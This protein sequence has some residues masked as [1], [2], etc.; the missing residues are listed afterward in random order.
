MKKML[1]IFLALA[2]CGMLAACGGSPASVGGENGESGAADQTAPLGAEETGAPMATDPAGE[3]DAAMGAAYGAALEALLEQHVFPDG[4]DAG[5]DGITP[6]EDSK[7]AV[8]DVDGDGKEELLILYTSASMAG[9]KGLVL[10]YNSAAGKLDT[11][12]SAYPLLTFYD[13]GVI[14]EE[15]SHNQGLGGSFWPYNLYQYN[16]DKDCYEMVGMV[17][18]WEKSF[19]PT[20][21]QNNPFPDDVDASGTG[22]VYYIMTD[23]QYDNTHPVDAA[24]YNQ[25]LNGYL[26]GAAPC[27]IEYLPLTQEN[28]AGIEK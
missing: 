15:W 18:A 1:S 26:G 5:F 23:G 16:P 9:M 3:E 10:S 20:D 19:A 24:E 12:L 14:R 2:L 7:F 6:M 13:N 28:I 11:E 22:M 4:T 8:Y 21:G 27:Q 17:D 25:W